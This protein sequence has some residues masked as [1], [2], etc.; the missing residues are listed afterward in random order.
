MTV[1]CSSFEILEVFF[2]S[3]VGDTTY[4]YPIPS[5]TVHSCLY[6]YVWKQIFYYKGVSFQA[7][8]LFIKFPF[9]RK[10]TQLLPQ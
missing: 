5:V 1:Y 9:I 4:L 2:L 3:R 10:I 8:Y 7:C 6:I